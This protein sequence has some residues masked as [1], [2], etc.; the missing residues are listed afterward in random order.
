MKKY[1]G[2]LFDADNTIFDFTRAERDALYETL[3]NA[4]KEEIPEVVYEDYLRINTRLWN[5]FEE[6]HTSREVLKVKRFELLLESLKIDADPAGLAEHYLDR[7]STKDYLLP[8]ALEVLEHLSKRALLLLI[9]NG[10]ARVQRRRIARA[11]IELFFQDIIISEEVGVSK[12]DPEF[13]SLALKRLPLPIHDILCVGDSPSSDIRGGYQA[14][15]DTCWFMYPPRAYPPEEP[16]PDYV[17]A[18]L[19]ELLRFSP[20]LS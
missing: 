4:F 8:N 17:A 18:D 11:G 12:P 6:G 3:G 9:S 5:D 15:I 2:F 10:I 19:R 13:F 16:K 14:G 20:D 7:L 1:H